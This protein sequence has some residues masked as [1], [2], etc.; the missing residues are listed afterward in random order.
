MR[1]S[2]VQVLDTHTGYIN[3]MENILVKCPHVILMSDHACALPI[4]AS[5]L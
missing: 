4:K 5:F 3:S 2:T 1:S